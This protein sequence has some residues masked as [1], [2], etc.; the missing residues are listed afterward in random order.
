MA[1]D[2]A[3]ILRDVVAELGLGSLPE[4]KQLE[5]IGQMGE[6]LMKRIMVETFDR[7]GEAGVDEFER[8]VDSGANEATIEAY[9]RKKIF[10]YDNMVEGIVWNF[11]EEMKR[12]LFP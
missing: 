5:L 2:G 9:F 6:V 8:L 10:A 11:K 1:F 4:E 3:K 12:D 7:L